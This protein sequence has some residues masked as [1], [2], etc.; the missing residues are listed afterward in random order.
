MKPGIISLYLLSTIT[1]CNVSLSSSVAQISSDGTLS[2]TVTSD[3]DINF[4]IENGDRSGNN[5]FHSFSDFSIPNL[6]EAYFNNDIDIVNIFSRVTGGNISDIQGLIRANGTANLFLIN[7]AGIIF[8]ENASLDIGGSFFASTAQSI[9]FGEGLEFSATQ[10]EAA[11]LLTINITPGLQMGANPGTIQVQGNGHQIEFDLDTLN[12][13]KENRPVGLQVPEGHTLALVGGEIILDGGNITA[14]DGRIEAW[15]ISNTQVTLDSSSSLQL[16]DLGESEANWGTITLQQSASMDASGTQGG[17]SISSFPAG[18]GSSSGNIIIQA[19]DVTVQDFIS[20]PPFFSNGIVNPIINDLNG[21]SGDIIIDAERVALLNGGLILSYVL[22]GGGKAGDIIIRASESLEISGV[23][24][25]GVLPTI[26]SSI[27]S[28]GNAQGGNIF[29]ETVKLILAEGGQISSGVAPGAT[30]QSGDIDIR[31]TEVLVS[32]PVRDSFD[33]R[34]SGINAAVGEGATGNAG[35][36]TI[37]ADRLQVF[38]GGQITSSNQGEGRA[39]NIN[40][41]V[42]DLEVQGSGSLLAIDRDAV[43][44]GSFGVFLPENGH[45]TPSTISAFSTGNGAAGSINIIANTLSVSDHAQISVSNTGNGNAGNLNI[46]AEKI[47]LD[48]QGS[49]QGEVAA[50]NQANINLNSQLLLLRNNSNITT[51]AGNQANG[52]NISIAIVNLVALENSDISANA[53]QGQGGNIIVTAQGLFLSPDSE[54]TASSEFGVDGVVTLNNPEA[55]GSAALLQL[56]TDTTDGSQQIAEGC[57]WV[58]TNS[59]IVTGRGGTPENPTNNLDND[60]MWSDLRYLSENQSSEIEAN[61]GLSEQNQ[62]VVVEANAMIV[63]E[64]GNV[65]LVAVVN[66]E[67]TLPFTSNCA[68]SADF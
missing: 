22:I 39:G 50:G 37:T 1:L 32:D 14:R 4:L 19:I 51:N 21:N 46:N 10:P 60:Q 59:F 13:I 68:S 18:N 30:G 56:P 16:S 63:N 5:L 61:G 23:G 27:G 9:V 2:T 62:F 3:D 49:L 66:T 15:A 65:E 55:D 34:I 33:G 48:T 44:N 57:A 64:Q 8:G 38:D 25:D 47:L 29:I 67:N 20:F 53:V 6:G 28:D 17:D 42:R 7:P 36:I 26:T 58:K 54:I 40:I 35:K 45:F 52:G 11:P 41:Q 12:F 24:P 31:A 43:L